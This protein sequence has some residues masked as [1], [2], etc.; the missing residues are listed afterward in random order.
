MN[1]LRLA[2]IGT[3]VPLAVHAYALVRPGVSLPV[4]RSDAWLV[5]RT[6]T[7]GGHR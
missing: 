5:R 1:Q 3:P 2:G 4:W 6:A 7:C